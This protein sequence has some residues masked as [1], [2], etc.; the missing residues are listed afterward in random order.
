MSPV[1]DAYGKAGLAPGEH[2]AAMC[3]LAASE[4]RTPKR[5]VG[6]G[7]GAAGVEADDGAGAS[8]GDGGGAGEV[9]SVHPWSLLA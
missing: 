2:R 1:G 9:G 6:E 5:A 8:A 3:C 7:A 4:G